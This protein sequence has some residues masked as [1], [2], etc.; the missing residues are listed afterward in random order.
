MSTIENVYGFFHIIILAIDDT[1]SIHRQQNIQTNFS[2]KLSSIIE[3][4]NMS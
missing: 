3:L 4:K 1:K 2:S